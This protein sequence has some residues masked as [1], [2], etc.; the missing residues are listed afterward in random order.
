MFSSYGS[1]RFFL[2]FPM[3]RKKW[4]KTA[5]QWRHHPWASSIPAR[6]HPSTKS[7][8]SQGINESGG[9]LVPEKK[10][11]TTKKSSFFKTRY[12]GPKHILRYF[13]QGTESPQYP[14]CASWQLKN[15]RA[16][17]PRGARTNLLPRD[18]KLISLVSKAVFGNVG[19]SH[20]PHVRGLT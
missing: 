8:G 9:G 2:P 17:R 13:Q 1:I 18:T 11:K 4:N 15:A 16:P 10:K 5:L 6:T 12:Y 19:N 3:H 14:L 20:R 7:S